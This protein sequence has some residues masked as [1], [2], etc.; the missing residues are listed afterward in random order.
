LSSTTLFET[1]ASR[2]LIRDCASVEATRELACA[3]GRRVSAG[4]VIALTGDLGSGKTT[5]VQGLARGLDV[6]SDCYVTSPSFTLINEYP[7]RIPLYHADLYRLGEGSD[8]EGIGLL[9]HLEGEG[10]VAIE[11][12]G[13]LGNCLPARHLTVHLEIAGRGERRVILC[14]YGLEAVNLLK[15][16]ADRAPSNGPVGV[17]A[18]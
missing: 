9:E 14:A 16:F 15:E 10:V 3:L 12:A 18:P 6:P 5:F 4:L 1:V 17:L 7:G 8:L 11:W 13:Y 2:C